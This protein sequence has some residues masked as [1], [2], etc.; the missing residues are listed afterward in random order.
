MKCAQDKNIYDIA[1]KASQKIANEFSE[2]KMI[3]RYK[4]LILSLF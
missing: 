4:E 3:N 2:E 1:K